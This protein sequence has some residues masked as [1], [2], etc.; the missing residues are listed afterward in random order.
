MDLDLVGK[1]V[2]VT[3]GAGGIG[4]AISRTFA[5]EGANVIIHYHSSEKSAKKLATELNAHSI[6]ADL[7]DSS[8]VEELFNKIKEEIGPLD[9][10]IANAGYYPETPNKLWEIDSERWS[11]TI[12][13]NLDVTVN[14]VKQF[15]LQANK[16]QPTSIVMIGSTAGVFG[17]A[18]HS[19]Y[20]TAKGAIT[21]GL[22]LSIK[23]EI[24]GIYNCRINAVAQKRAMT[25]MALKKLATPEDVANV[26]AV[27][28]S[29][30]ISSHLTGE[31]ITVAGGMEG[32]IID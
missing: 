14:T 28:S 1:T 6:Y 18:G 9:I 11:N 7:R 4:Q 23:N 2:L 10:C 13:S 3:G 31:I 29:N 8:E 22:L 19:D 32:R 30:K 5:T 17:E 12:K 25:T 26:V 21:S 16:T 27:L 20:A 15:L 24:S